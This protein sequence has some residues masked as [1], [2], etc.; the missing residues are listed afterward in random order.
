F[1]HFTKIADAAPC[2]VLLYNVPAR[3]GSNISA[4]T[5][6]RLAEHPNIFGVKEAGID[7]SQWN[8]I[9]RYKPDDFLL[10]SG[11][12]LVTLSQIAIGGE[13]LI[14]VMAN[15]FPKI[16]RRSI[17]AALR[18]DFMGAQ[19]EL[20]R[21]L[22]IDPLMYVESNPVGLKQVLSELGVCQAQV[23]LPL[24]PASDGLKHKIKE[25]MKAEHLF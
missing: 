14:S 9:A 3:T 25:L 12:D 23:R 20:F 4:E 21:L 17:E 18:G 6:L 10:I 24:L 22:E 5:I 7:I 15:A 13:G 2:P 19:K 8:Q 1:Q 16:I 11:N